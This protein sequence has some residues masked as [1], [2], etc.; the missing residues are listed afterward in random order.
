MHCN[1]RRSVYV[2]V[3]DG[4]GTLSLPRVGGLSD[5]GDDAWPKRYEGMLGGKGGASSGNLVKHV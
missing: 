4:V 1:I 3:V 2:P 5:E